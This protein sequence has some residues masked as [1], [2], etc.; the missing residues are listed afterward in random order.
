MIMTGQT[1]MLLSIGELPGELTRERAEAA[2]H[3]AARLGYAFAEIHLGRA[4]IMIKAQLRPAPP[5]QRIADPTPPR[6]ELFG[7]HERDTAQ[8]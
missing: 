7:K 8:P 3:E 1:K 4:T 2:A 6:L 5:T